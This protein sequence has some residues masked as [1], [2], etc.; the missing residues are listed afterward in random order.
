MNSF[1]LLLNFLT[2]PCLPDSGSPVSSSSYTP[3]SRRERQR[4]GARQRAHSTSTLA[5]SVGLPCPWD[6]DGAVSEW[7][8]SERLSLANMDA[9]TFPETPQSSISDRTSSQVID[10]TPSAGRQTWRRLS[11]AG[12]LEETEKDVHRG[13]AYSLETRRLNTSEVNNICPVVPKSPPNMDVS[14]PPHS[15]DEEKSESSPSLSLPSFRHLSSLRISESSLF[16]SSE[17]QQPLETSTARSQQD[18]DEVFLQSPPP[19]S[20]PP[21]IKETCIIEDFPPPPASPPPPPPLLEMD[22]EHRYS[23]RERSVVYVLTFHLTVMMTSIH[24]WF[25]V[26]CSVRAQ[27]SPTPV[28][29]HQDPF[30]LFLPFPLSFS[31]LLLLPLLLLLFILLLLLLLVHSP[32]STPTPLLRRVYVLST[33]HFLNKRRNLRSCGWRSWPRNWWKLV[34]YLSS[35]MFFCAAY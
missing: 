2:R 12:V 24:S 21:P 29:L 19:P 17:Q 22:E 20:P 27:N 11:E 23:S 34:L 35:H 6:Q 8:S 33:S 26:L 25:F 7:Q 5:A 18:F 28:F 31:L 1:L 10:E 30:S 4:N 15:R 13:R 9:I 32:P 3:V 16:G 14:V